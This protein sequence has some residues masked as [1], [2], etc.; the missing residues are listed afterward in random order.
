MHFQINLASLNHASNSNIESGLWENLPYGIKRYKCTKPGTQD[1][2][3][4]LN[5]LKL[6][7][8]PLMVSRGYFWK[9]QNYPHLLLDLSN[10]PVQLH[11]SK[12]HHQPG[13]SYVRSCRDIC[14]SIQSLSP[15]PPGVDT[16]L[17][18]WVR[19]GNVQFPVMMQSLLEGPVR[20]QSL[21]PYRVVC[22]T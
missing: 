20:L 18:V 21:N 7:S 6:L 13:T 1:A 15:V 8:A 12:L 4:T 14:Q 5:L 10:S 3:K 16:R 11:R 9:G 19:E 17:P 2:L 22:L